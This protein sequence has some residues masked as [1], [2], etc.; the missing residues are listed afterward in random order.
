V[1]SPKTG[2]VYERRLIEQYLLDNGGRE[3]DSDAELDARDLLAVKTA[4]IVAPRPPRHT[5]IPS[6]LGIFQSEWD[7]L[8][9]ETYRLREELKKT[10]EELATA[11]YQNDAAVR[12]VARVTRE[13]D[14]ARQALSSLSVSAGGGG[15]GG[16]DA[17]AIDSA[18][19]GLPAEV[20]ARV[21]QTQ[22][23]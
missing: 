18:A 21:E 17:M 19:E 14:E 23:E 7:A 10:R 13:R 6:L 20:I 15:G 16:D 8:A 12:V 11:L 22:K 9:L 1:V 4:R 2:V 3:P 5:S